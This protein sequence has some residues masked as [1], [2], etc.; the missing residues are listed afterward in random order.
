MADILTRRK[1]LTSFAPPDDTSFFGGS[2]PGSVRLV[3]VLSPVIVHFDSTIGS[4]NLGEI[5]SISG[6]VI[7]ILTSRQTFPSLLRCF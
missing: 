2:I 1:G 5:S 7:E 6:L 3:R 4:I